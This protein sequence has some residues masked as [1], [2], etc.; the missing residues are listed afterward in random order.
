MWYGSL[1]D[2]PGG[3]DAEICILE[4]DFPE[5]MHP[6][7]I[8]CMCSTPVGCTFLTYHDLKKFS[9]YDWNQLRQIDCNIYDND[10]YITS[11]SQGWRFYIWEHIAHFVN[12]KHYTPINGK[13]S[14][15]L[16]KN[17]SILYQTNDDKELKYGEIVTI[18][19][20]SEEKSDEVNL[21]IKSNRIEDKKMHY[22]QTTLSSSD[23]TVYKTKHRFKIGQSVS[24]Y[25]QDNFKSSQYQT[26]YHI[27]K[28][29]IIGVNANRLSYVLQYTE[30]RYQNMTRMDVSEQY[31]YE[32]P[33]LLYKVGEQVCY[34]H[35]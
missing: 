1:F 6:Q 29:K 3:F 10:R 33:K 19:G 31:I 22:E 20:D 28:G 16:K 9:C 4:T 32:S 24:A 17:D 30:D 13:W 25:L 27:Y 11:W 35:A 23:A 2:Y 8:Q 26:R 7:L 5:E 34:L 14:G 15:Y 18:S 12:T 21:I